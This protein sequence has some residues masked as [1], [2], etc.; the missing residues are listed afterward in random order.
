MRFVSGEGLLFQVKSL[1]DVLYVCDAREVHACRAPPHP[2]KDFHLETEDENTKKF[3]AQFRADVRV[4]EE[5]EEEEDKENKDVNAEGAEKLKT[6]VSSS[7]EV[8]LTISKGR[9]AKQM[10]RLVFFPGHFETK[11]SQMQWADPHSL[12]PKTFSK[13]DGPVN[14]SQNCLKRRYLCGF[15]PHGRIC[16]WKK[17]SLDCFLLIEYG[18]HQV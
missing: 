6:K 16:F 14:F 1:A 5:E 2:L 11:H 3:T 17:M 7:I 13:K 8:P 9:M 12:T 10:V 15:Y 4:P 18:K